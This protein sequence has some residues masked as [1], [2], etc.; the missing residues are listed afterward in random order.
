MSNFKPLLAGKAPE[1]LSQ[2]RFPVL[3]SPK[4]DGIRCVKIGGKALSRHLKPIPNKFVHEWVEANLPDG[5]DGELMLRD[6]RAPFNEVTSAIMSRDGEPDFVF[7]AFDY[8]NSNRPLQPF[9]SRYADLHAFVRLCAGDLGRH[10]LQ[11]VPH[12]RVDDFEQ[13]RVIAH[14]HVCDGYEGSMVRD[15]DGRY[16]FGRSTTNE[17]ILLKIKQF[18]D[19]EATVV[20]VEEE[21]ENTNE[22]TVDALGHT[23]R[24]TKKEGMRGKGRVGRLLCEFADGTKFAVGSGLND[25]AKALMWV[26]P[27]IGLKVKIK[28]QPPPGG[29]KSG[30]APR[31]PVFLGIRED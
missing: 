10:R 4:L 19:E 1:D 12:V 8:L 9:D 5:I 11:V 15:P 7:Q 24:S 16:K 23:E 21:M 14:Q 17:G 25:D 27:P 13:L 28:H 6:H 29:R 3:V 31:F 18:D 30:E 26:K 20:G 2:L 22:A